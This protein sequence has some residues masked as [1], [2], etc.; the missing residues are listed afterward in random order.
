MVA[1]LLHWTPSKQQWPV[2]I[3]PMSLMTMA[4][5]LLMILSP[6]KDASFLDNTRTRR[7]KNTRMNAPRMNHQRNHPRSRPK[8]VL[9]QEDTCQAAE[10]VGH[11]GSATVCNSSPSNSSPGTVEEEVR[12]PSVA[13]AVETV[14]SSPESVFPLLLKK[15][16]QWKWLMVFGKKRRKMGPRKM[17]DEKLTWVVDQVSLV[18]VALLSA[19]EGVHQR[20]RGR[21]RMIVIATT[22]MRFL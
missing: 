8:E 18:S 11:F 6:T 3:D 13:H 1:V 15:T 22:K 10:H 9:T 2:A 7:R 5:L 19:N 4:P 16:E 17:L 14:V 21:R 12:S 20:W